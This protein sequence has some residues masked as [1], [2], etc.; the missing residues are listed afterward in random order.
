MRIVNC[1]KMGSKVI[2]LGLLNLVSRDLFEKKASNKLIIKLKP[3]TLYI[4]VSWKVSLED[5]INEF[6]RVLNG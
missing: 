6:Q 2:A 4:S 3:K 5:S 1:Q